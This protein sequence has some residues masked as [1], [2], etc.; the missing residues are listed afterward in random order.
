[1]ITLTFAQNIDCILA[2]VIVG[3]SLGLIGGGGSILAVPLLLYWVGVD[4]PHLVIGTTALAVG[5]NAFI[6]LIPHARAGNVRWAVAIRFTIAGVIGA[7]AGA[8]LGK[9]INGKYLLI[10]FALLMLWIALTMYQTRDKQPV[11]HKTCKRHACV[12]FYGGGTGILSGFFGIGGGFLIVPALMRSGRLPILNAV[13]SSLL[14]V[15]ALGTA[16]AVSYSL[17][18]LVD[19]HIAAEYIA[20][21]ILGGWLGALSADKLGQRKAALNDIFIGV[22]VLVAIY[23][24]YKEINFFI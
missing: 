5:I 20:G 11:A 19:W 22:I 17:D 15:G 10:L 1:M 13:A 8:E 2:G 18:G 6:N 3:F 12:Y 14:A 16:T 23:M 7:F 4:N 9:A 24:L 21:G